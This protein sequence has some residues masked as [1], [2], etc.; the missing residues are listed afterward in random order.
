MG[1]VEG[2]GPMGSSS[3]QL[4]LASGGTSSSAMGIRPLALTTAAHSGIP[5]CAQTIQESLS[6]RRI[7]GR[8][9]NLEGLRRV[10]LSG[11]SS[12]ACRRGGDG[13]RNLVILKRGAIVC[14]ARKRDASLE[15]SN[16]AN[17]ELLMF[18][19]Q[20][21][22]T[23]RLQ[24][25]LNQ[26]MYEAAQ[27]LREKIAEVEQEMA[28]QRKAKTGSDSSKNEVQDTGIAILQLK[29]E[30]QRLIAEEDY[31]AA[32]AIRNKLTA[33]EA[34]SLAAQVQAL[35]YQQR[36]FQFRLGQKV[37]HRVIGYRG[38]VCGMDPVCCESD[39]WAETA[40][41]DE[42]PRGRNQPFYQVLVDVREEPS[43]MV[44]YVA[45]DNLVAPEEPDFE[46][47]DH[48]YV[49]FLFYGMDGAGD[50]IACKQLREKYDAPRHE[51]PYDE[52]E[53]D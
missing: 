35:S 48:P 18:F 7:L 50:F 9:A 34:E 53:G 43:V 12:V 23:T 17:E 19:F 51:L 31:A 32:G 26:D 37:R 2:K 15:R 36:S 1:G 14:R 20:L 10:E 41:V 21:D 22:L 47:F 29:A 24:R 6:Y 42:L 13:L 27:G 11:G 38:V 40:G 45:E 5:T 16:R 25:A 49:Y 39:Q 4:G 30:L 8:L 33:L 46:Q 44:T 3:V 28:R 52:N